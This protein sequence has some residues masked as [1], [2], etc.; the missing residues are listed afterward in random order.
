MPA[1]IPNLDPTLVLSNFTLSQYSDSLNDTKYTG[2]GIG[3]EGNWMVVVLT[4]STPEGSFVKASSD[5][6]SASLVTAASLVSPM[7]LLL[8]ACLLLL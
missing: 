8:L 3:S 7:L 6:V 5:N 4:T 1:C 2:V